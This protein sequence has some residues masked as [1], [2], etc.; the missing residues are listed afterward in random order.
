M[1]MPAQATDPRLDL[2]LERFIDVPPQLVW[3]AWTEPELIKQWFT[4][5]PWQTVECDIDLRPGGAFRTVMQ[6]PEGERNEGVGC[7]LEAVPNERF[8]WTGAL[9]PDFR[10]NSSDELV[11]TAVI[12]MRPHGAGGTSYRAHVM[13]RDEEGRITH[14]KMGF[15]EGWGTA[16]DQLVE[17]AKTL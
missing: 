14:E 5:R 2:V 17:L 8:T 12:S 11:F 9:L 7:I 16:L 10:P 13:H 4:P 3:R 6:G 1:T 15:Y